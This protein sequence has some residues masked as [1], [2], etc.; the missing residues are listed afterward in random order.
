MAVYYNEQLHAPFHMQEN[1]NIHGSCGA[2]NSSLHLISATESWQVFIAE[3]CCF[4]ADI[5]LAAEATNCWPV[6][7]EALIIP[8]ACLT[9]FVLD[10]VALGQVFLRVLS[11]PSVTIIPPISHTHI[12]FICHRHYTV[13]LTD[14]VVKWNISLPHF[15][16]CVSGGSDCTLHEAFTKF[17]IRH[18]NKMH[19]KRISLKFNLASEK[20]NSL[21]EYLENVTKLRRTKS[22]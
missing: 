4:Y 14:S 10:K 9:L 22:L 16:Y 7:A 1:C 18:V 20:Y 8:Q 5:T 12:S 17:C 13:S 15:M 21:P 2:H 6:A 19:L 3:L 11:F